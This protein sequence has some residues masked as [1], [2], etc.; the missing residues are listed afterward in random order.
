MLVPFWRQLG[1]LWRQ[2]GANMAHLGA[3]LGQLAPN[4]AQLGH[5]WDALDS[6][7]QRLQKKIKTGWKT[8]TKMQRYGGRGGPP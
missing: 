5:K 8:E 4:L 3:N 6:L 7:D 1:Q 2:L